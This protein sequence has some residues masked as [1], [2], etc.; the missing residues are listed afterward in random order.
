MGIPLGSLPTIPLPWGITTLIALVGLLFAYRNYRFGRG[1]AL[2]ELKAATQDSNLSVVLYGGRLCGKADYER[3][4]HFILD[5]PLEAGRCIDFPFI[6]EIENLGLRTASGVSL[7]LRFPKILRNFDRRDLNSKVPITITNDGPWELV[8]FD[9]GNINPGQSIVFLDRIWVKDIAFEANKVAGAFIIR[10]GV[11]QRDKATILGDISVGILGSSTEKR[12]ALE[13]LSG[14]LPSFDPI[15]TRSLRDCIMDWIARKMDNLQP[16]GQP[17]IIGRLVVRIM[18]D[19]DQVV[20][21]GSVDRINSTSIKAQPGVQDIRGKV[22]FPGINAKR[23]SVFHGRMRRPEI[24]GV[25]GGEVINE[26]ANFVARYKDK[27]KE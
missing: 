19:S 17:M 4:L 18:Y 9:I 10:F 21:D 25:E 7:F 2:A 8:R 5:C 23:V 13:Q 26:A 14:L 6:V 27:V 20:K 22:W 15:A 1:R 11:E 24:A 16:K 3:P 12:Y